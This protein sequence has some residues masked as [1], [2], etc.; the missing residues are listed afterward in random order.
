MKVTKGGKARKEWSPEGKTHFNTVF[1]QLKDLRSF[2]ISKSNETDLFKHWNHTGRCSGNNGRE[3][4]LGDGDG[5]ESMDDEEV[6]VV[7]E[8]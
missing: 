8:A 4:S 2:P 3:D 1:A 5:N 7:Y 6:I